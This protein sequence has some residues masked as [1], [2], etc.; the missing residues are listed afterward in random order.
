MKIGAIVIV[1]C[2]KNN[3]W[4]CLKGIYDVCDKVVVVY[5]DCDWNGDIRD[6]GTLAV[7]QKFVDPD[8]KLQVVIGSF[9]SQPNQRMAAL[10]IL[11]DEGFDYCFVVDSDEIYHP[12]QLQWAREVIES[13]PSVDIFSVRMRNLWKTLDYMLIPDDWEL[14]AFYRI[15]NDFHFTK[16]RSTSYKTDVIEDRAAAKALWNAILEVR[17]ELS[18]I[19]KSLKSR[20]EELRKRRQKKK[21]KRRKGKIKRVRMKVE[22]EERTL[23][24]IKKEDLEEKKK[25]RTFFLDP[26]KIVCY[27]LTAVC[28]DKQML[29]KIQTRS[30]KDSLHPGWYEWKWLKWTPNTR[31]LHPVKPAQYEKAILFNKE[32]LPSFMKKHSFWDKLGEG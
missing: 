23:G 24:S 11:K 20:E 29:E 7:I 27:H 1:N 15:S 31:N 16:S 8:K 19:E 25:V 5:S 32:E 17:R 21:L 2:D 18:F 13:N 26:D 30:Y 12:E 6:D 22:K 9:T 4:F 14:S 10:Q 3:I 28:D